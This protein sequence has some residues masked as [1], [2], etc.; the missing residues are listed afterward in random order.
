MP[1]RWHAPRKHTWA[2]EGRSVGMSLNPQKWLRCLNGPIWSEISGQASLLEPLIFPCPGKCQ[3]VALWPCFT[4]HRCGNN[5]PWSS[6]VSRKEKHGF[7]DGGVQMDVPLD[8]PV[9]LCRMN[10]AWGCWPLQKSQLQGMLLSFGL[11]ALREA[12]DGRFT[13][14]VSVMGHNFC[15]QVAEKAQ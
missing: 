7:S 10:G 14:L 4:F 1:S 6:A 5:L 11:A 2:L 15:N 13:S 9:F 8:H 12:I 3:C